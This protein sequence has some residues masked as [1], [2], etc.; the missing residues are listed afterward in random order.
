MKT[1]TSVDQL[2]K[3]LN[4]YRRANKKIAFIPTMGA[5]HDGHLSLI[6]QG[7]KKADITVCSIFV[8]PTQFNNKEDLKKYPRT[9]KADADLLRKHKCDILFAPGV[10][11]IYPPGLKTKVDIP[12]NKLDQVM[13]GKFRPGHFAGMLQVVKRL[14]DI[15]QPDFLIMGQKDF[16]QFTLV[17]Y[18]IHYLNLPV[19]LI[20]GKIL[21]E[22]TGLAMSS[23]NVRLSTMM[24]KEAAC[25]YKS[26]KWLKKHWQENNR[27]TIRKY[28]KSTLS[29]HNIELEYIEIVDGLSLS[30]ANKKTRYAVACLACWTEN[31]RLIDNIILKRPKN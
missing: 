2:Q 3:T 20:V 6:N 24:R 17:D 12:L 11:E 22:K 27:T 14:L 21:R 5:L 19:K 29:K 16:Q 8:N 7:N 28:V 9:L 15:V 30:R 23:R 26:L 4:S 10:N 13:E 31:V 25:I 18:M 1:I